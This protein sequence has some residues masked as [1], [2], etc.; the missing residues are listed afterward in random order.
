MD[1]VQPK[2]AQ[3]IGRSGS[4]EATLT[5]PVAPPAIG[6]RPEIAVEPP[7]RM[8]DDERGFWE[9][10][11]LVIAAAGCWLFLLAGLVVDHLTAWPHEVAIGL[12]AL[13]YVSGGAFAT[14]GALEDLFRHRTVNVDLLMVTAAIGAAAVDSWAEGAILLGLF[15]ASGALEHEALGRTQRAV[16]ALMELSPDVATVVRSGA[17]QT[18]PVESL[19]LG[20]ECLVR[21]GGRVPVDGA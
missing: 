2:T 6:G 11:R 18:V 13:A 10:W 19:R 14:A 17:E 3:S 9:R 5:R 4:A 16:K 8:R 12:F 7:R 1:V 15:S 21:P 20:D